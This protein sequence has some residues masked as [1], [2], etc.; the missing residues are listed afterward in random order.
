MRTVFYLFILI[1]L[2]PLSSLAGGDTTNIPLNRQVFH[3]KIN[4][5]QK[6][7]DKADGHLDGL[8]KVS[9]NAEVNLQVT[10]A[11]VRKVNVL[12][13]DIENNKE[14]PTN[15]DK[16]RYLRYIEYLL[17]TFT[18]DW[19]SHKI[20]PALAP[21]L[22]DNFNEILAANIKGESMSPFI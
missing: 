6:R 8:I 14:L 15:N 20:S 3:D 21:L 4:D 17:K 16:I 19:K 18:N 12:R 13:N 7:A 2:L 10:D 1:F 11:I 5:E 9:P 22:V